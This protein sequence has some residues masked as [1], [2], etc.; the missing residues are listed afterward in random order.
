M[1]TCKFDGCSYHSVTSAHVDL[2]IDNN[3]TWMDAFQFGT[4][5]DFTWSLLNQNF[6]MDVK[7]NRYDKVALLSLK[8]VVGSIIIDDIIQR[9]IHFNVGPATLQA[10]L[11]PG[12]YVYDLVMLDGSTPPLSVALMHGKVS[13]GQGVTA[14]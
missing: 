3:V 2:E 11:N 12:V 5:G 4:P 8:S 10:T 13:V 14:A 7:Y 1:P 6:E 9:V